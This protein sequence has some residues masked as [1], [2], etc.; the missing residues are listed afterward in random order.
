MQTVDKPPSAY[1]NLSSLY[2]AASVPL[3]GDDLSNVLLLPK[4]QAQS[5]AIVRF[6]SI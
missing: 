6:P 3:F 4:K 5:L 1:V 2:I